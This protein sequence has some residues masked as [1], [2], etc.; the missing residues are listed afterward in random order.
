MENEK[1]AQSGAIMAED[2][3]IVR[4]QNGLMGNFYGDKDFKNLLLIRGNSCVNEQLT[5]NEIKNFRM[6]ENQKIQSV[7]WQGFIQ[8][9]EDGIYT[10]S[11]GKH[12]QVMIQVDN[13]IVV[14]NIGRETE[15]KLQ[16]DT[17][18]KIIVEY[19]VKPD[20]EEAFTLLWGTEEKK[21][22]VPHELLYAPSVAQK[23]Q[24]TVI[25]SL[26]QLQY[27]VDDFIK[28]ETDTD[29]DN[30]PDSWEYEGYTVVDGEFGVKD[31]V[32]WDDDIHE[33]AVD[34]EGNPLVKYVSSPMKWSTSDDPYSD[35][36]K[37]TGIRMDTRVTKEAHHPLVAAYPD[38]HIAME[39][40]LVIP[41]TNYQAG[42]GEDLP[43]K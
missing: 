28:E 10:F 1:K 25:G 12:D 18:Y 3:N 31:L 27:A 40:Y 39:K 19:Q 29:S 20:V 22:A 17:L 24:P 41:N 38:V 6:K 7:R 26:H 14:D 13:C 30:I 23:D 43:N 32:K 36:E 21:E 42:Q 8:P 33:G 11:T 15:I 34:K 37:V 16:K 2:K 9:K 35:Y 4:R 5:S